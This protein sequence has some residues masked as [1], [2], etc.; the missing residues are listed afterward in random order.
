MPS[1]YFEV[2]EWTEVRALP[3]KY[4]LS[5]SKLPA[6]LPIRYTPRFPFS[7]QAL[8]LLS[9]PP[10]T[11]RLQASFNSRHP[12]PSQQ[13]ESTR[14]P[15]FPPSYFPLAGHP[16]APRALS[17]PLC[18]RSTW[19][20]WKR[21]LPPR[22]PPSPPPTPGL[23]REPR[24][25]GPQFPPARSPRSDSCLAGSGEEVPSWLQQASSP[26]RLGRAAAAQSISPRP[27]PAERREWRRSPRPAANE[28]SL[29]E[30]KRSGSGP[31]SAKPALAR[32]PPRPQQSPS[33]C[34]APPAWLTHRSPHASCRRG[35]PPPGPTGAAWTS[36]DSSNGRL[37]GR[38]IKELAAL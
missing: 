25:R 6:F 16:P 31:R 38:K 20:P 21:I 32:F 30:N 15:H 14:F 35:N 27:C 34:L 12:H 18:L 2:F 24:P 11:P 23:T 36:S 33:R 37:R 4:K 26:S 28:P 10:R 22:P 9:L 1:I 13:E 3:P 19:C 5:G 7:R 8:P 17:R 29:K